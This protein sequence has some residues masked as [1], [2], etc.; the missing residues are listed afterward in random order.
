MTRLPELERQLFEAAQALQ[1]PRRRWW[2]IGLLGGGTTVLVAATAAGAINLLLPEGEP[3]PQA[4]AQQRVS[5]PDMD[6]GTRQLVSL[7]V[8]DP[9]GGLPWGFAVARSKDGQSFCLQAG[10]VQNNQL[11]VIGRDETFN[12]DGRFHR[13]GVDANQSGDCGGVAPGGDLRLHHDEPPIPASGFTGSFLSPAGGCRENVPDSTMSPETRRRLRDVPKCQASSLRIVRYGLAGRDAAKVEYGGQTL[14][15][16]PNES[17]AY[18]FVLTPPRKKPT[19]R[20]TLKDGYVCRF[21]IAATFPQTSEDAS[22][23]SPGTASASDRKQRLA[24]VTKM[25]EAIKRGCPISP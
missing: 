9:E 13:L 22:S 23:T 14:R 4:P 15:T 24:R 16:D 18:L 8:P 5:L 21:S 17:G 20:I 3:V 1:R 6:P 7:R 2:R 25:R 19:L 11:G 12:N 10:R